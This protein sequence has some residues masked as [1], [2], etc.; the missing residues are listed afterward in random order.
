[1]GDNEHS[2]CHPALKKSKKQVGFTNKRIAQ[3][4]SNL[5][6][7]ADPRVNEILGIL[8]GDG[9][10]GLSGNP[11]RRKQV[12][13]CGNLKSE[14]RYRKYLQRLIKNAFNVRGYYQERKDYNTYYIII[15]SG[16]IFDFFSNNFN[17]P[18]GPKHFF[19]VGK[20]PK[21][22][23][24]QKLLIRGI[25]DTDGSTFFD[26]DPRYKRPYPVLDIT[27]K[28]SEVLEWLTKTLNNHDFTVIRGSKYLR[29]KGTKNFNKWFKEISP[30]NHIHKDKYS[31]WLME[32]N[33]R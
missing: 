18:I 26:R 6:S 24:L 13:F 32:Y 29:L 20:F 27:L 4:R 19:N 21:S 15:N 1:M 16:G 3:I 9:W 2:D 25:F 23:R 12:C 28:N 30:K 5:P 33:S 10:I 7:I 11:R 22:W 31:K 17:F 8:A 14:T